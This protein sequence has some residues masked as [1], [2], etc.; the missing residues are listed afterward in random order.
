MIFALLCAL[1]SLA[2]EKEQSKEETAPGLTEQ[3]AVSGTEQKVENAVTS[4]PAA[5]QKVEEKSPETVTEQKA[6]EGSPVPVEEETGIVPGNVTVNFKGADIRTVLSYI[7]EVAGID[8]VAAPEV[9]G[10]ID[11]KLTNKPW[12]AALDIITRNYG[13]TYEREGD[14]IRVIT[15]DKLKQ[16]EVITQAYSLN[17]AKAKDVVNSLKK[18][19]SARGKVKFDER[20]NMLIVTDI[21]TNVYRVGQIIEKLDRETDQVLIEARV[22]ET[23]LSDDE[24]VGIDWNIKFAAS[25]AKRPTTFPFDYFKSDSKIMEKYTPLV[26]TGTTNT[27]PVAGTDTIETT[28]SAAYPSSMDGSKAFPFVDLSQD[29]FKN[30]FSFGTLDFSQF[31]AVL[32]LIKQRSDTD[33]VSNPRIATLNNTEANI[34]VGQTLNMPK[35]ERN[36][37]TGKVEITGYEAKD[38]GI[39]L[40]VTPHVNE[41]NEIVVDLVP[42]ISDLVRYDLIDP[43]NGIVAPVYSS[44]QANTK[45]MIRDGDTIFIGG[46]IK[47]NIID[48]KKPVPLLGDLLG[49]VPGIGLLFTKKEK[50]KQKTEL[51][52]F[53]TVKLMKK[54]QQISEIPPANQTY[55]PNYELNQNEIKNKSKRRKI[56]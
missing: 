15:L 41:K 12:K 49:D 42:E 32:E 21:P 26:Q 48:V 44:R 14:I 55:A 19:V 37:M 43:V 6:E 4:E 17:Y 28:T 13:F 11:L 9:K 54:N 22:L 47:E 23:V 52:F 35:Y 24:R 25:G 27:D 1:P 45:V 31:S 3:P 29:M 39:K 33:I 46:L 30:S 8:I 40:K 53:I 36:S 2:E 5:E 50:T 34:L 56:N 16:E 20:T 18:I 51:I 38:L 10:V 7:S